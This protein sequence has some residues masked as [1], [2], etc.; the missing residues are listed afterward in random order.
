MSD[1]KAKMHRNRSLRY[2]SWDKRIYF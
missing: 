1:F 2:P